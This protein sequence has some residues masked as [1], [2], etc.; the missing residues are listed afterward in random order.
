[1]IKNHRKLD[2][3]RENRSGSTFLI[4]Q[5]LISWV[6]LKKSKIRKNQVVYHRKPVSKLEKPTSESVFAQKFGI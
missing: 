3:F 2:G 4:H 5:K 6:F 1:M